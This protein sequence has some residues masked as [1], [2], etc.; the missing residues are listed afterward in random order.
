MQSRENFSAFVKAQNRG[1]DTLPVGC[2]SQRMRT[3]LG[4]LAETPCNDLLH[5]AS[6]VLLLVLLTFL[7]VDSRPVVML[8]PWIHDK[9]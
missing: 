4:L 3:G 7:A 9:R 1:Y 2:D 5:L 8:S 6:C